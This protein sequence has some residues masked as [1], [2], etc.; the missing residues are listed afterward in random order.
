MLSAFD[1]LNPFYLS[2]TSLKDVN[3]LTSK[4]EGTYSLIKASVEANSVKE[5]STKK[6]RLLP[7][8]LTAERLAEFCGAAKCCWIVEDFHKVTVAEKQKLAQAMKVFMD[9]AVDYSSV[10]VVAIGAVGTAR[11]VVQYDPEM[12]TRVAEISVPLLTPIELAEI[13]TKGEGLLNVRFGA[14]K[15]QISTYASGLGAVC[16]QLAL[17]ICLKAGVE[18][19]ST[20]EFWISADHLKEALQSYLADTSDTLKSAFDKALKRKRERKFDNTSIIL[21]A[22]TIAGEKGALYADLLKSIQKDIP[23]YPQGN[24]TVYLKELTGNERGEIVRHDSTSGR[25]H[26][27]DP[28]YFAYA[29]CLFVPPS[30]SKRVEMRVLGFSFKIDLAEYKKLRR[31]AEEIT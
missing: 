31:Q 6:A 9:T 15:D 13:L 3:S 14:L 8:Q 20:Q 18:S 12:N 4:L 28:L 10:R 17:N 23:E 11:E 24:L 25:Y 29:Q 30:D 7:P 5:A 1:K 26:F 22:L 21:K 2:E 16:H 19:T 27:N